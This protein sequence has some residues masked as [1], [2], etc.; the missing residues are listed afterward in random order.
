MTGLQIFPFIPAF[1]FLS[2]IN[3]SSK[4]KR[5]YSEKCEK[6]IANIFL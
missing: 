3:N 4:N 5:K 2:S 6:F 1:D